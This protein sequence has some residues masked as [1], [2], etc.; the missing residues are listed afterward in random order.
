MEDSGEGISFFAP[1]PVLSSVKYRYT[2]RLSQVVEGGGKRRIFAIGN[3]LHQRMLYP[4]HSWAMSVLRRLP[5]DGTF[6][7]TRPLDG[8][9]GR[10]VYY[11]FDL[12]SATDRWPLGFQVE[13]MRLLFGSTVAEAWEGLVSVTAFKQ[14]IVKAGVPV[15]PIPS[16]VQSLVVGAILKEFRAKGWSFIPTPSSLS[17]VVRLESSLS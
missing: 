15:Y 11:S 17:S 6:N 2:G 1:P 16:L 9:A 14:D 4:F 12:K 10:E 3:Y 8:L 13:L 7:Q 5:M